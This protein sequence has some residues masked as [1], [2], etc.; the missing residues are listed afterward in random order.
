MQDMQ[1]TGIN[2]LVLFIVKVTTARLQPQVNIFHST[3]NSATNLPVP[4]D[5]VDTK[6]PKM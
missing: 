3:T 1:K 5:T 2:H 4:A 6:N